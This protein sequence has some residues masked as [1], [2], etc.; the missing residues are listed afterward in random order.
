MFKKYFT[1]ITCILNILLVSSCAT[2]LEKQDQALQTLQ[3]FFNELAQGQYEVA[4]THYDGSYETLVTFNPELNPEDHATLW[5][6][7]CQMNGLK[8]LTVRS[9]TFKEVNDAGE[10]VFI[11]EFSD[12]DGNLFKLGAC[13]GEEPSTQTQSQFDYR[14]VEGEDGQFRVLDLPIYMP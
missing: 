14:V 5:Q 9:A 1:L 4:T 10:F 12:I 3:S 11:V 7:G 6:S 8:C 2:N 13:C